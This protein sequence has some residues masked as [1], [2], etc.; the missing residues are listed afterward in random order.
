MYLPGD[1]VVEVSSKGWR[2]NAGWE[3]ASMLTVVPDPAGRDGSAPSSLDRRRSRP[4]ELRSATNSGHAV[5]TRT[6]DSHHAVYS[7]LTGLTANRL[8]SH[9]PWRR[10]RGDGANQ[11]CQV[12]TVLGWKGQLL[13]SGP[14]YPFAQQVE[15]AAVPGSLFDHVGQGIP[16]VEM[17]LRTACH[18]VQTGVLDGRP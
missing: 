14:V 7:Q 17:H 18:L 11:D 1:R 15:M 2:W 3:D 12:A 4:A 5:H 8:R 10:L 9:V 16:Q 6:R 13:A